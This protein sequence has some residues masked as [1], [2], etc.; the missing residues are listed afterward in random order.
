MK[1]KANCGELL[2]SE[3]SIR[4]HHHLHGCIARSAPLIQQIGNLLISRAEELK[5]QANE[6]FKA[7]IAC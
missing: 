7:I 1:S 6:A 2:T 3:S 4:R 5:N